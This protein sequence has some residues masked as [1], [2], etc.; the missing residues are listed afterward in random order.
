MKFG[1]YILLGTIVISFIISI[2]INCFSKSHVDIRRGPAEFYIPPLLRTPSISNAMAINHTTS[3]KNGPV[4]PEGELY[5]DGLISEISISRNLHSPENL[6]INIR[7]QMSKTS[8]DS[9]V[10]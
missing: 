7:D 6:L 4:R 2:V 9:N 1:F 3:N 8:E 10:Q 5:S